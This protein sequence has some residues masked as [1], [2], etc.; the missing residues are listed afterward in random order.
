[1][2]LHILAVG[3]KQPDWIETAFNEYAK[4][5]PREC[6]IELKELKPEKRV[7]GKTAQQVMTAEKARIEAALP[8]GAL[9]VALD[10]RGENWT[11]VKLADHMKKWLTE[12][13]DVAFVIGGADG[14][15]PSIKQ[16]AGK[17]LQLSAMTLPHGMVRVLLAE[18][19]YRAW[20]IIN[21]HPY[22]RE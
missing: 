14:L 3:H 6:Q 16:Q 12:G 13:R 21:N 9:L 20:S 5:M 7:G 8:A 17:L 11:T 22:H 1:M 2:R 10:E 19:L 18:Q 15:E 4:R